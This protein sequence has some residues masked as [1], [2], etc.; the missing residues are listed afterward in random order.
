MNDKTVQKYWKSNNESESLTMIQW[1]RLFD[2]SKAHPNAY[3]HGSTIVGTKTVSLM[4]K[5]YI[6][7]FVL[8]LHLPHRNFN[9]LHHPNHQQLPNQLQW[10]AAALHHFPQLWTS[11]K[12]IKS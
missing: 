8:L 7:Q 5:E 12:E 3:K 10:F 11:D 6:F 9:S 2:T 4:S 1:L